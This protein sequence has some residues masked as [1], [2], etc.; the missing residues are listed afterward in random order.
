[1][2]RIEK[3]NHPLVGEL[4][5][6]T[7]TDGDRFLSFHIGASADFAEK[8]RKEFSSYYF[9]KKGAIDDKLSGDRSNS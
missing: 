3:Y 8:A 2:L 6:I 7:I 1:M 4:C 5:D 9:S